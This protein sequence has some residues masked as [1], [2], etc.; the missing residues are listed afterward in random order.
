MMESALTLSPTY[1]ACSA[2]TDRGRFSYMGGRGGPLWRKLTY[3][4]PPPRGSDP[5]QGSPADQQPLHHDQPAQA[6]PTEPQGPTPEPQDDG[7]GSSAASSS[8]GDGPDAATSTAAASSSICGG[9]NAPSISL[10]PSAAAIRGTLTI[11][12]LAAPASSNHHPSSVNASAPAHQR[13]TVAVVRHTGLLEYLQRLMAV[14]RLRVDPGDAAALPFNFWGG[15]V[16]YLGYE[17]KAECGCALTHTAT[18][19]DAVLY[20]ADRL[21]AVDHHEGQLYLLAMYDSTG[22]SA[23]PLDGGKEEQAEKAGQRAAEAES[24]AR[25]WLQDTRRRLEE[26]AAA[27]GSKHQQQSCSQAGAQSHAAGSG[28]GQGATSGQPP[29]AGA[30]CGSGSGPAGQR[31]VIPFALAHSRPAYLRN[32]QACHA[33]LQAGESYEVCLTTA[34]TRGSAPSPSQLYGTLRRLNPAPYA[35][36]L[37]CGPQG[38]RRRVKR[39]LRM[40]MCMCQQ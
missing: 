32:I 5:H 39:C 28:N 27:F 1:I 20:V 33:A 8:C 36:W 16:G 4:L 29:A 31:P 25:K 40:M 19:P 2:A 9:P 17:L 34:L 7:T 21:V 26:A 15:L 10:P 14:Q 12:S 38:K 23:G 30:G 3:R 11:E 13:E 37:Q 35:A 22:G 24:E 18:T 6:T